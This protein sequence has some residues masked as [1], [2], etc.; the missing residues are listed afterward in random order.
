MSEKM[1]NLNL[2]YIDAINAVHSTLNSLEKRLADF[3][4]KNGT[5]CQHMSARELAER[6]GCSGATVVRFAR[7]LH[8]DGFTDLKYH[9][10]STGSRE[11]QDD[12]TLSSGEKTTSMMQKALMY[13]TSSLQTTVGS[14]DEQ[15]LDR[16]ARD[17][18][19][20][21]CVQLCAMGSASGVALAA[22]SQFLS[23]GI[24]ASFPVDELQQLRAAAC[25][26]PGD[27]LIGI[28]YN[29]SAKSVADAFM[30]AKKAGAVTVLITAV[31]NGVLARYADFLFYTPTRRP[32]N[33]L[34]ISTSTLCQSM[35]L[36]LLILRVWQLNPTLFEQETGRIGAYTKMKLYDPS[37]EQIKMSYSKQD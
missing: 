6:C 7:K 11:P 28:N 30:A 4:L 32:N 9:I 17:I 31:K 3:V 25:L 35:I 10:R 26:K 5:A 37:V 27:V 36:Q 19:G 29:N 8:Y 16:A 14:V 18:L 23:F 20:A 12:I 13:A 21:S 15:V 33:A 2:T 24:R 22:C 1:L 34:N